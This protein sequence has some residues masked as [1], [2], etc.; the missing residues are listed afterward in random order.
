[1]KAAH[2]DAAT[3]NH[4]PLPVSNDPSN[5]TGQSYH[6]QMNRRTALARAILAAPC[7]TSGRNDGRREGWARPWSCVG[8]HAAAFIPIADAHGIQGRA[9]KA[10]IF[11]QTSTG[12]GGV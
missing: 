4:I 7:S 8:L 3:A 5:G 12:M 1:M 11:L 10:A 2:E 9:T 6:G